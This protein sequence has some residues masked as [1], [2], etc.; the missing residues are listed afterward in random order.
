MVKYSELICKPKK[1]IKYYV[2]VKNQDSLSSDLNKKKN[3]F[4]NKNL[5]ISVMFFLNS[6]LTGNKEI[7]A[8]NLTSQY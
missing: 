5:I 4:C 2:K 3:I 7:N 6:F 1:Y 8:P